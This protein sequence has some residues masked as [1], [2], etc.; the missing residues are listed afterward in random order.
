VTP[1]EARRELEQALEQGPE[2]AEECDN[3]RVRSLATAARDGD[4]ARVPELLADVESTLTD[5]G[6]VLDPDDAS[7]AR[8]AP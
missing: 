7:E 6:I 4:A 2:A 1:E 5:A 8:V 3:D